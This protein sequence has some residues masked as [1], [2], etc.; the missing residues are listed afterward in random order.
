MK[1][2]TY[3]PLILTVFQDLIRKQLRKE[4]LKDRLKRR[5]KKE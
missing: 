4:I 3:T 5:K 1:Q 2:I